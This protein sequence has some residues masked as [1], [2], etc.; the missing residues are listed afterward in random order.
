MVAVTNRI[1]RLEAPWVLSSETQNTVRCTYKTVADGETHVITVWVD[2]D[3]WGDPT[4]W[5]AALC[6]ADGGFDFCT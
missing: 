1:I 4:A 2:K 6:A 3:D 5:Q